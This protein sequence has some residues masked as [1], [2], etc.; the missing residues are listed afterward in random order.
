MAAGALS[1]FAAA[2]LF[3]LILNG[4]VGGSG[5]TTIFVPTLEPRIEDF[6][7][8]EPTAGAPPSEAPI[9]ALAIPKFGVDAPVITLGTDANG[10]MESPDGPSEVAWYDFSV[11]P[12]FGS[13][14]V[15]SGHVDYYNYGPAVFWNLR[16]LLADDVIE[17][18][19]EDGTV[20]QYSVI[21]REMVYAATAPL[22]EIVGDTPRE[23]ITLITCGG[24]FDGATY[25]YDQRLVVRAERLYDEPP[26]SPSVDALF[27]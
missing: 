7:T 24:T 19:L 18:R 6:L 2:V 8:P 4:T 3:V 22:G 17:V 20:Y 10:V 15:F 14:A 9:A 23:V 5:P 27:P 26:G 12:G 11:H 13:N 1:L 25:T 21:S 16:D